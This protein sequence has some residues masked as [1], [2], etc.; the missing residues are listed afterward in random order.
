M[1]MRNVSTDPAASSIGRPNAPHPSKLFYSRRGLAHASM[2][3]GLPP[4][5]EVAV[6]NEADL[7]WQQ[8]RSAIVN[9]MG[10]C[11]ADKKKQRGE[12]AAIVIVLS[13]LTV[14]RPAQAQSAGPD[15]A[16]AAAASNTLEEI[17]VTAERRTTNLQQTPIAITA[18]DGDQLEARNVH[19]LQDLSFSVPTLDMGVSE[20]QAHPAIRGIGA[21]DIIWGAD[22]RVGFYLNDV[23]LPRPEEQLGVLFDVDQVQVLNGPQG[24]LYGRN[25]T[26][27]AL[28]VSSR[29]PTWTP[30]G[31]LNV[32][33]GNYDTIDADGALNG[34]LTSSLAGRIAF[35]TLDHSGY[36]TN[37]LTGHGVDD[38]HQ[39]S[40]RL[41][42]LWTPLVNFTFLM[43]GANHREN[44][45]NYSEH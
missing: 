2:H 19:T 41:G 5:H 18:V 22:P 38:A 11:M 14:H 21:S 23:Y 30:S 24:T 36:G 32:T 33:G 43:Q 25:A 39:W 29:K 45:S 37:L 8:N 42:L 12:L 27:G 20:G 40:T 7:H 26:G 3:I 13:T 10:E 44:D 16:S 34:P 17:V 6:P 31:Y 4:P 1:Q 35:E 15:S 28:L 9:D